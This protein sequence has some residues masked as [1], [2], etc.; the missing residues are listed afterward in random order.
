[1]R[2]Q[3]YVRVRY[4]FR[5]RVVDE[6]LVIGDGESVIGDGKSV[7]IGLVTEN[8]LLVTE[9]RLSLVTEVL[10]I[11]PSVGTAENSG[12]MTTAYTWD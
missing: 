1:M 3:L 10:V 2:E 7:L 4:W 11:G 9:N 5:P 12:F 8:R 6:V